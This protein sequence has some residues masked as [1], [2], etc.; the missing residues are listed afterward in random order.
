MVTL[1]PRLPLALGVN[2]T[3]IV[4]EALAASVLGL[5]GHGLVWAKSPAFVPVTAMLLIVKAAV[6]L[7][8]SVT[9]LAALVVFTIW[10]PKLRL[11]ELRLT[12]GAGVPVP[13][14][15]KA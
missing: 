5:S 1:A 2:V 13:V 14:P 7:L 12:A 9:V 15:L 6:P 8:V 11:L 10:F 3:L 4:Q